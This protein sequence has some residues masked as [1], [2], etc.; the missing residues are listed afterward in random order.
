MKSCF[1]TVLT[2]STC[3]AT[4]WKLKDF[5]REKENVLKGCNYTCV[6]G[7]CRFAVYVLKPRM[8]SALEDRI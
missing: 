2:I 5:K 4:E 8:V 7:R 3:A 1:Q 6:V